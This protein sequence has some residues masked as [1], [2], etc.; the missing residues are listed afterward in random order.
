M[1]ASLDAMQK[2]VDAI[3]AGEHT[4]DD[5]ADILGHVIGHLRALTAK[6]E[7]SI[8]RIHD[9]D[10]GW[11]GF[12][13]T[14]AEQMGDGLRVGLERLAKT[15]RAA[16]VREGIE[17]AAA[18]LEHEEYPQNLVTRVRALADEPGKGSGT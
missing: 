2:A 11:A 15:A 14:A 13:E 1:T 8:K 4:V 12:S 5:V 16:G 6:G 7:P 18:L 9:E 17:M 10:E 3:H